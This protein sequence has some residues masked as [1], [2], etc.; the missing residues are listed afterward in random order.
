VQGAASGLSGTDAS[1]N[2][3][4]TAFYVRIYVMHEPFPDMLS[5]FELEKAQAWILAA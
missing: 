2:D 1:L 4:L 5:R 3:I